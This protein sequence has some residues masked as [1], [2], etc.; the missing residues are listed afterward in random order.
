MTNCKMLK[1]IIGNNPILEVEVNKL[2]KDIFKRSFNTSSFVEK[3]YSTKCVFNLLL[4]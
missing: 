1:K 4:I 3:Y 2:L